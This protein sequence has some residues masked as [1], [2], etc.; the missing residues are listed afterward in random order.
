MDPAE[1]IVSLWLQQRGFFIRHNV[2]VGYRGKEIDFL[3]VNIADNKRAHVEV[4]ASVSPL[5]PLRPWSPAKYGR[6]PIQD[7]VKYYY[8]KKFVGSIKEG[9]GELIN[10]SVEETAR[11]VLGS[12]NYERWLVLGVLHKQDSKEQLVKEFKKYN[13]K[14]FFLIDILK[15][16]INEIK[17]TARD[18]TGRFI[19]LLVSQL[20]NEAKEKSHKKLA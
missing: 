13:V 12:D 19:Q 16:I 15:E 11:R 1:E 5:G 6:I 10:R 7:R 20:R 9:T 14:V 18:H 4:H 2:K 17:G 3:A 8:L